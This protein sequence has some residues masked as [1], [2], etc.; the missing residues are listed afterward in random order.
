MIKIL[1]YDIQE[2]TR[3]ALCNI[4]GRN[5]NFNL[6]VCSNQDENIHELIAQKR[7]QLIIIDP[8]LIPKGLEILKQ[9]KTRYAYLQFL[10]L[11][12]QV[13][14]TDIT[15]IF[16]I[17]I[18]CYVSKQASSEEVLNGIA[19]AAKNERYVCNRVNQQIRPKS[20]VPAS[21][22]DIPEFSPREK[23]IIQLIAT[24]TPDKEIAQKL[25]LSFHT[26]R[27]HR[28]NITRKLG[29]SL[30]NAAELIWLISYLNDFI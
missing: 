15:S 22:T 24:G 9:L 18:N 3:E 16:D 25:F 19:A 20:N 17:G 8:F 2:L 10:V 30:K 29:F 27:T 5:N 6:S 4:A 7:P 28:K 12:N 23:E 1:L 11:T 21:L 13:Q 26:I 14:Y